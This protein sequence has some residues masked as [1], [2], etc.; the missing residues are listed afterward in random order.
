MVVGIEGGLKELSGI[1]WIEGDRGK[2]GPDGSKYFN[3]IIDC[4][5]VVKVLVNWDWMRCYGW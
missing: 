2:P 1:E 3:D 5:I 4:W